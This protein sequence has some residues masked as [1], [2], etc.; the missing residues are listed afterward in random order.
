MCTLIEGPLY[1][2]QSC[3][4]ICQYYI[5]LF[6]H[7]TRRGMLSHANSLTDAQTRLSNKSI[8]LSTI[9]I[10]LYSFSPS[11]SPLTYTQHTHAL[12]LSLYVFVSQTHIKCITR[13]CAACPSTLLSSTHHLCFSSLHFPPSSGSLF[14]IPYETA[15]NHRLVHEENVNE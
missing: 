8:Q 2:T 1:H 6:H 7:A 15:E 4:F 3:S 14:V 13:L 11:L 5:I 10:S 9:F 12:S